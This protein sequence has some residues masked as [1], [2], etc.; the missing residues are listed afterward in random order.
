MNVRILVLEGITDRG[1]RYCGPKAGPSTWRRRCRPRE[2]VRAVLA[3]H[4]ILIRSGSQIN[5]EVL[6][7][8]KSLR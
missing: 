7:A 4:A 1:P 8:A 2:L 6:D 3:Y 5:A